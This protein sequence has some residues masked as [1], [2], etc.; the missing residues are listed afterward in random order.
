MT[1]SK[2]L[3]AIALGGNAILQSDQKGTTE[4]QRQNV[5]GAMKPITKIISEG[6][7]NVIMTHGNGP[8]A[9][10]LMIQQ[11]DSDRVPPQDMDVVGSMTQGQ[12]GYM[13]QQELQDLL[14]REGIQVP[15]VSV[16][17]QVLVDEDDPEFKGNNASK[18]VGPFYTEEEAR[19]ME[20]EEGY[21]VKKVIPN[22][23]RCWRR[24]V[25]S[26]EPID[27]V[28]G[29]AIKRMVSEDIVV[30]ASGGGGIPVVKNE[31]GNLQGVPA[32]I[33]KDKSGAKLAELTEAS[34]YLIL[35]DVDKVKLNFGK[36]DEED[37]DEMTI[38]QA[39]T[40][41]DQGHFLE[42]SMKPKVEAGLRFLKS[43]GEKAII[44]SLSNAKKALEDGA[45]THIEK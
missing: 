27:N 29:E 32:V 39:E 6:S 16:I 38:E 15:V 18:P 21:L 37:I 7:Y 9:G 44:T 22:G 14:R 17:N 4:Q 28:E 31:N 26:P 43:G 12:I 24:V 30:V 19:K 20:E 45:G 5:G 34:V 35:T 25:P 33:D 42:G 36:E 23:E 2:K 13:V 1:D 40:Y 10:A 41:I 3:L 8:Q 11:E